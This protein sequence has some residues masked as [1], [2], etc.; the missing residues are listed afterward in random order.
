MISLG[1]DMDSMSVTTP[2]RSLQPRMLLA[3]RGVQEP[4]AL[5][6]PKDKVA[7]LELES[8]IRIS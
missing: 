4:W 8:H 1:S 2:L 3:R 7:A 5:P 6:F